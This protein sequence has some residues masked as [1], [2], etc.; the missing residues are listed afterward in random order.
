[1]CS[2]VSVLLADTDVPTLLVQEVLGKNKAHCLFLYGTPSLKP[3][4]RR[5]EVFIQKVDFLAPNAA[6]R[7]MKVETNPTMPI[8]ARMIVSRF[9]TVYIRIH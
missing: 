4:D 3:S 1:M 6:I 8:T 7:M 5:A 9:G 2:A